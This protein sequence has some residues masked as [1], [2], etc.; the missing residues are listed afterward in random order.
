MKTD[1]TQRGSHA[2]EKREVENEQSTGTTVERAGRRRAAHHWASRADGSSSRSRRAGGHFDAGMVASSSLRSPGVAG[3]ARGG[4]A[5][6][7]RWWRPALAFLWP[8]VLLV[9]FGRATPD[10][11]L[12]GTSLELVDRQGRVRIFMDARQDGTGKKGSTLQ[13]LNAKGEEQI[14][15]SASDDTNNGSVLSLNTG[16]AAGTEV[17]IRAFGN[18]PGKVGSMGS[19]SVLERSSSLLEHS[20]L[21]TSSTKSTHLELSGSGSEVYLAADGDGANA[22]YNREGK[23]RGFGVWRGDAPSF[24][25]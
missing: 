6:A 2:E 5:V 10:R 17:S 12:R 19:L 23:Y 4:Q 18:G 9:A 15:L 7:R 14:E 24:A 16:D 11:T 3:G 8:V 25:R 22:V 13:F 21:L 20:F 1:E